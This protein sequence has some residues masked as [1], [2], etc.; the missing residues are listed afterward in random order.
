MNDMEGVIITKE[1]E[2]KIKTVMKD[3]F[4]SKDIFENLQ[5]IAGEELER[6]KNVIDYYEKFKEFIT[7]EEKSNFPI[8]LLFIIH[9][10]AILLST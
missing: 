4:S 2:Q 9:Y 6:V 3:V 5:H 8:K 7:E 10:K 1:N